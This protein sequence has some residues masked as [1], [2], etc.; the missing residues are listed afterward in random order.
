MLTIRRNGAHTAPA[1]KT[2]SFLL[3]FA[4]TS[5]FAA[6]WPEWRGPGGQG[7]ALAK[8]LPVAWSE[9]SGIAWKTEIPGRGW[10]K[11]CYFRVGRNHTLGE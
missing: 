11:R 7:L 10:L 4:V 9:T 2:A 6:E 1:M 3:A 5:A 8:G